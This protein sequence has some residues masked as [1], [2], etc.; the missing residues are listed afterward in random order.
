[1]TGVASYGQMYLYVFPPNPL[2]GM[3][4]FVNKLLELVMF[5]QT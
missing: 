3:S 2:A 5:V 4:S 1:M